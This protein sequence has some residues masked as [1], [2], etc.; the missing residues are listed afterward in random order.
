[1]KA[2]VC[3]LAFAI[4]FSSALLAADKPSVQTRVTF[5][6]AE[7][8]VT[9]PEDDPNP[10][11]VVKVDLSSDGEFIVVALTLKDVPK[12]STLFQALI[13]GVAFDVDNSAKTGG[14]GFAGMHGPLPGIDFESEIV[15][16]V[17]D[18]APSKSA[19]ASVIS[20]DEKGN[21]ASVLYSFD[22]PATDAKGKTYT[23][24]IA[25][26]SIGAKP[27]QVIRTIVRELNDQGEGAGMFP[28]VMLKLK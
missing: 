21:Q 16:A 22:A 27:G 8:D 9:G 25:Y 24:K 15:A 28:E 4:L 14:H 11:D 18:G 3:A 7:G 1:M 23:G 12:P 10:I 2:V 6:D 5:D 17:D 19:S 26:S 20:V 13:A